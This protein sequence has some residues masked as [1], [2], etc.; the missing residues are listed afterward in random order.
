MQYDVIIIVT[1]FLIKLILSA[2]LS[3]ILFFFSRS[4]I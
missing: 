2:R 1:G 3:F 4:E